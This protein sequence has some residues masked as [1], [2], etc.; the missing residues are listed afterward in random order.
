VVWGRYM[1]CIHIDNFNKPDLIIDDLSASTS[2]G[3]DSESDSIFIKPVIVDTACL[4]NSCVNNHVMP[5]SKES[6]T[7]GKFVPTFHNSGKIGH[8]T[9]NCYLLKSHGLWIKKDA[10]RKGKVEI[11]PHLNMSLCIGDI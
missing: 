8:I 11:L 1:L 5:K 7:Q 3:S 4:K 9:P 10:P 2:H 6:G